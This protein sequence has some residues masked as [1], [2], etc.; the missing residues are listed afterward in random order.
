MGKIIA[1]CEASLA[2]KVYHFYLAYS[3]YFTSH[4]RY[5]SS[6]LYASFA[7]IDAKTKIDVLITTYYRSTITQV[8]LCPLCHQAF[9]IIRLIISAFF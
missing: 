9:H 2:A 3:E 6:R 7:D 1:R 5:D 4:Q 8:H